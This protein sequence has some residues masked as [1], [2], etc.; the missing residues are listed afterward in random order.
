MPRYLKQLTEKCKNPSCLR[1]FCRKVDD[2]DTAQQISGILS[3]YGGS[4]LCRKIEKTMLQSESLLDRDQIIDTYFYTLNLISRPEQKGTTPSPFSLQDTVK[5]VDGSKVSEKS[6]IRMFRQIGIT[7]KK[8]CTNT[9]GVPYKIKPCQDLN[10]SFCQIA[11]K[12]LAKVDAYLLTGILHLLLWKFH[13]D[14]DFNLAL[15]IVRLFNVLSKLSMVEDRYFS[16]LDEVFDSIQRKIATSVIPL[17]LSDNSKQCASSLCLFYFSFTKNDFLS[18]FHTFRKLIDQS[19]ITDVRVDE[20]L[21]SSFE[22]F[23]K[24]YQINE[25]L[26]LVEDRD[27]VLKSFFARISIKHELRFTKIRYSSSLNYHFA[28]PIDV[29]AE[30]LKMH[31]ND[32]MKNTLQDAFF[33]ALFE[34]VTEPYFFISV[35]RDFVYQDTLKVLADVDQ[36]N[37]RKQLKV[38]FLGEEGID[39]G[40]IKKE[41]F[42][43]L[44]H[45]IENDTTLF[46]QTNNRI[47]FKRGVNLDLLAIIG[48]IIGISLYNDVVL[49]VPFPAIIFKKLLGIPLAF[50]ELE[51]IEP[52]IYS[53]LVNLEKCS[54]EDLE[55]LDQTFCVD[56]HVDDGHFTYELVSGGS[57]IKVTHQNLKEFQK[58][59]ARLLTK[60][61]IEDEFE[62]FFQGFSSIVKYESILNF[63][64]C[65]L[66][67]IIMGS[68]DYDFEAIR[69]TTTY[70][71]YDPSSD[72]IIAYFWDF[73]TE[74]TLHKKKKLIQFI[75]GN[76]RL[77]VGG[78]KSL[79]LVI[80]KNGCNTDRLPSSQTCFNT[81]LL[82][83][84]S[85]REKLRKKLGKAIDL[86]AGFF[87]M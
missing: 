57:C 29:K 6:S 72:P 85:T 76:D 81:L 27:F 3:K 28:I 71:G 38:K 23:Q 5:N 43:L 59:Y 4:L 8:I 70:N 78:S 60:T 61:L 9:C 62:A 33:R 30:I 34:G 10:H 80:M 77:P 48:K 55:F 49:N 86:T 17:I 79:S 11:D 46:R 19:P 58:L 64:P 13:M 42:L 40:G 69:S 31:N 44:G 75:T 82:P 63:R 74:L 37:V 51:E 73:F 25:V 14:F 53:S 32:L 18:C 84:Y 7:E 67:K 56:V 45:E 66:E 21:L 26:R 12:Q 22:I 41:F 20:R 65:E 39:S 68:D 50:E 24:I 1:I 52:E 87:L 2:L 83:E 36:E 47:W 16:I 54:D 15:V 35:R